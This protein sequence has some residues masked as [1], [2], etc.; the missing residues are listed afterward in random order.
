MNDNCEECGNTDREICD[1]CR[2]T[3]LEERGE[4]NET[5]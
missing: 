5:G 2:G 3:V 4:S 1:M